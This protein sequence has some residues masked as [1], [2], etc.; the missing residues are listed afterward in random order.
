MECYEEMVPEE[1]ILLVGKDGKYYV[2]QK[3]EDGTQLEPS[4]KI[5]YA[6]EVAPFGFD[7]EFGKPLGKKSFGICAY[8]HEMYRKYGKLPED[9]KDY[10]RTNLDITLKGLEKE[11]IKKEADYILLDEFI[12][13]DNHTSWDVQGRAQLLIKR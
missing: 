4:S 11:L 7:F 5:I 9:R 3:S 10:G 12:S 13:K 6:R 1:R 8:H 2:S